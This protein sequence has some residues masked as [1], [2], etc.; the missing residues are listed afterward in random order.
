MLCR[1]FRVFR[2]FRAFS[3]STRQQVK[4]SPGFLMQIDKLRIHLR[5]VLGFC[6][7]IYLVEVLA[8][9]L[10]ANYTKACRA[11]GSDL[12][13]NKFP[14]IRPTVSDHMWVKFMWSAWGIHR[15]K[16]EQSGA[17]KDERDHKRTSTCKKLLPPKTRLG[18][19]PCLANTKTSR[20]WMKSGPG[21]TQGGG[22]GGVA[23]EWSNK[24]KRR[25]KCHF[26]CLPSKGSFE[27]GSLSLL[28][29][30]LKC[31]RACCL[32]D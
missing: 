24:H 23:F 8:W 4:L 27:W 17:R 19:L 16:G 32:N 15:H 5:H 1:P 30:T 25:Q 10:N 21:D 18:L 7:S 3:L 28:G 13:N 26:S 20:I 9:P 11:Q 29:N 31:F 14:L 12:G 2:V 6:L 22:T